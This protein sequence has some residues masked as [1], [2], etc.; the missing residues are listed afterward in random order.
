M[1]KSGPAHTIDELE[2]L[3]ARVQEKF[4]WLGDYL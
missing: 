1:N 2:Q 3:L 4:Q